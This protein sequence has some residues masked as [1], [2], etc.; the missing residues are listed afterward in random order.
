MTI[1]V[2]GLHAARTKEN[3]RAPKPSSN[4]AQATVDTGRTLA[5]ARRGKPPRAC[6]LKLHQR[7]KVI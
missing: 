1:P 7:D 2:L 6:R 5:A 4:M 3:A